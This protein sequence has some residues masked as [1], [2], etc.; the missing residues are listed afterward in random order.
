MM[1]ETGHATGRWRFSFDARNQS[2]MKGNWP[3]F[4]RRECG[5]HQNVRRFERGRRAQLAEFR[6][7]PRVSA[8]RA[9]PREI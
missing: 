2:T 8:R 3:S 6:T 4:A 1:S 9:T 5:K 7:K